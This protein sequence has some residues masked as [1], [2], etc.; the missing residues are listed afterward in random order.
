MAIE[1][2]LKDE[3]YNKLFAKTAEEALEII[4]TKDVHVIVTDM[5]MPGMSGLEL[6]RIVKDGFPNIIRLVLSAYTQPTT[7]L[8]A[9]NDGEIFKYITKPWKEE[10]QLKRIIWEAIELYD[11]RNDRYTLVAELNKYRNQCSKTSE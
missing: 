1:R 5:R 3:P 2:D 6:L 9:I 4:Q 7:L 8:T 11:L 10:G